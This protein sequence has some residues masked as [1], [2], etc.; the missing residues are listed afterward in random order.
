M[1]ANHA[2][3]LAGR[4]LLAVALGVEPPAPD[5][6]LGSMAALPLPGV[7]VG[8]TEAFHD[9]L[10]SEDSIQVPII[11]W[12]VRAALDGSVEPRVLLR[13]SAQRYNEPA[14]Y[15]RLGAVLRRRLGRG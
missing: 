9:A 11:G 7:A 4:D 15:E 2:L 8:A 14:D 3:A 5:S 10:E 6:M 12:P 1:A 13:I